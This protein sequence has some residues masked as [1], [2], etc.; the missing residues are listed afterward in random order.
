M[1]RGEGVF[2]F[3]HYIILD[4]AENFDQNPEFFVSRL[5]IWPTSFIRSLYCRRRR[6]SPSPFPRPPYC[7][8]ASWAE[9]WALC[10]WKRSLTRCWVAIHLVTQRLMQPLSRV[11]MAL[12]VKSSTQDTKQCSTRPPKALWF[13]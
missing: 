12:E 11:E 3:V 7:W 9:S 6:G 10:S 13:C 4:I 8:F 5:D 1:S 2:L